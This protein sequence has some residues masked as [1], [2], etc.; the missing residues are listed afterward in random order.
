MLYMRVIGLCHKI[1][2][3]LQRSVSRGT[4]FSE[5]S[6]RLLIS[7]P[8]AYIKLVQISRHMPG[9]VIAADVK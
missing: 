1:S 8:T 9:P 6:V 3:T 2:S 4:F 7:K 5:Y